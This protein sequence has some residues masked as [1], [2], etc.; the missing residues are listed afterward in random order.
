MKSGGTFFLYVDHRRVRVILRVRFFD[1]CRFLKG[2]IM[3]TVD[4]T[5]ACAVADGQY[6]EDGV[7]SII[8][9]CNMFGS[10]SFKLVYRHAAGDGKA[11]I[12]ALNYLEYQGWYPCIVWQD[13]GY[14]K[15]AFIRATNIYAAQHP[16][17]Q[18]N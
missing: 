6:S 1:V 7:E 17:K 13:A 16:G 5:T 9:Y 8:A 3:S 4:Y 10:I 14:D 2:L 18:V 15:E 11:T 12:S